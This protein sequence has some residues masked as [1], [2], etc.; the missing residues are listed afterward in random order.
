VAHSESAL[1][2]EYIKKPYERWKTFLTPHQ[3]E[4]CDWLDVPVAISWQENPS[5]PTG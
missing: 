2:K 1:I 3:K 4:K 5:T